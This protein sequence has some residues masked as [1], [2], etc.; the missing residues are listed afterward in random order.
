MNIVITG[1]S[2]A[3]GQALAL[4]YAAPG[5][6]LQLQG[7]NLDALESLANQCEQRGASVHLET[8][9]LFYLNAVEDWAKRLCHHGAPDLLIL[10]AGLNIHTTPDQPDESVEASQE[11]FVVNL[12]SAIRL[13]QGCLPAM[14]TRGTGQ[15]ALISSL[16]AWRGLPKTPSYSA[17]KA[18]LKAYGEALRADL[19]SSGIRVNVV[20]PG[21]VDSPMSRSMPG[22]K[23]WLWTPERA[24]RVIRQG[25]DQNYGRISFPFFLSLGCHALA[26]LPDRF[27]SWLLKRFGYG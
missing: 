13:V 18:G 21:Y 6:T 14:R 5:V 4:E 10:N 24:A 9:D 17:S 7:R 3:I 16:A 2:G 15:I 8:L 22:P 26:L 1:A 23:P 11:L 12:L 19:S 25:L 27:A 20:L